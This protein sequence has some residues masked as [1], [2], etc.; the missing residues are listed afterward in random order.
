MTQHII[1]YITP[2][3]IFLFG[4]C[5]GSFLNVVI[6]RIPKV[7]G[8]KSDFFTEKRSYCPHCK[9]QLYWYHNIPLFSYIFLNG[10]CAFCKKHISLQYPFIELS[11]G[12][13][14]LLIYYKFGFDIYNLLLYFFIISVFLIMAFIDYKYQIVHDLLSLPTIIITIIFAN[15]I[16]NFSLITIQNTFLH[17]CLVL[18]VIYFIKNITENIF[19]KELFGEGDIY[20]IALISILFNNTIYNL[21]YIIFLS[22]FLCL[23]YMLINKYIL[24]STNEYVGFLPYLFIATII[25]NILLD[26]HFYNFIDLAKGILII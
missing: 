5:I 26:K 7:D 1:Q 23:I 11:N 10:K 18:G 16:N 3:Y 20:I 13:L 21:F 2:L 24:K 14:Y 12:L 6:Y 15:N 22:S 19:S 4:L 9:H 25:T 17:F 8:E